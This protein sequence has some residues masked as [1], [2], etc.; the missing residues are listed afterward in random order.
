MDDIFEFWS[1]SQIKRGEKIH[2]ADRDVFQ[3][4]D[5]EKH[6]FKIKN[7]LPASYAGRLRSAP[8]VL[9]YLSPGFSAQ[10]ISDALS[11]EGKDYY[12]RRWTGNEPIS[13]EMS[14][15][16]WFISRTKCFCGFEIAKDKIAIL[17]IGAYHSKNVANYAS[18]LA[19]PSSRIAVSW[20]QKVLFPEAEAGNR[21]VICMRSASYWGLETGKI[22][23]NYLFAP[24]VTRSG[25]LVKNTE[26]Q[27]IIEIVKERIAIS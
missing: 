3:R 24:Q 21:I 9:L 14:G 7:C 8:V 5:E 22:Y 10:D 15:Y 20:A 27:K 18:L 6:G 1:P 17:N 2:P 26:R 19:L 23:G 13:G 25:H 4:I 12:L 11:D 16:E